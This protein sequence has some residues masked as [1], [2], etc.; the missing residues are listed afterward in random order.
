MGE[1]SGQVMNLLSKSCV[2]DLGPPPWPAAEESPS[3]LDSR[4]GA[5]KAQ[6]QY[7]R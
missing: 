7:L 6:V 3:A 2:N 1:L 4:D 5:V